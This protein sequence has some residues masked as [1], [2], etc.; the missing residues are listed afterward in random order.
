MCLCVVHIHILASLQNTY[1]FL[2]IV[3]Q[4]QGM[5]RMRA[6]VPPASSDSHGRWLL[7]DSLDV[8]V[9]K[10]ENTISTYSSLHLG[11]KNSSWQKQL[12]L[13]ERYYRFFP[14]LVPLTS[15]A[16]SRL[17]QMMVHIGCIVAQDEIWCCCSSWKNILAKSPV[18]RNHKKSTIS[19]WQGAI[20]NQCIVDNIAS[21]VS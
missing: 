7:D 12:T 6:L 11:N 17:F 16:T 18:R 14:V 3:Q 19:N 5:A 10:V 1:N 20:F 2:F 15:F 13:T 8:D 4:H 9:L 21:Y